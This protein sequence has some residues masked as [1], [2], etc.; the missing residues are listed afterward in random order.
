MS[1][2]KDPP[3]VPQPFLSGVKVIDFGE[4]RIARGF[5]RYPFSLCQHK[6]MVYDRAERRIWCEECERNLDAFDVVMNMVE[7][8]DAAVKKLDARHKKILEAEQHTIRLRAARAIDKAWQSHTTVPMC[9]HCS[10]GLF[11][12]HFANEKFGLVGKDYARATIAR[13]KR[14]KEEK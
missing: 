2:K 6:S 10:H 12:E 7:G 5:S 11:P 8:F 3:I 13:A 9:P 4:I 14:K 1:E